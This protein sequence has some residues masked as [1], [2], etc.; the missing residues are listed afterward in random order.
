M[1]VQRTLVDPAGPAAPSP[2]VDLSIAVGQRAPT[3]ELTTVSAESAT[4]H[5]GV[6]VAR[7]DDLEPATRYRFNDV[8]VT[9]LSPPS[10][11]LR[12]RFATVNDVHFGEI[13]AGRLD[14]SELGPIQRPE[15]GAEPYPEVMNRAAVAEIAADVVIDGGER[16][17][18][19]AVFV[20]GDLTDA[21]T[22]EQFAAFAECYGV[23]G[24]QLHVVRG[25]HDGQ[26]GQ[27]EYAG[28]QWVELAGINVALLDTTIAGQVS[29]TLRPEQLDWLDAKVAASTV[30]VM[31]LGH[32][33]MAIGEDAS[34]VLDA[35]STAAL[36]DLA[37]RRPAVIAYAAGHTHRQRV[38]TMPSSGALSIEIACVKDFPGSW[39]SYDVF[40]GG[41]VQLTHRI[42]TPDA[43]RWSERCR[44]LYRD[45]GL[46]YT[47]YALGSIDQRCFVI[48]LR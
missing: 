30:P 15:P 19:D 48:P 34:M 29:G 41:V 26:R 14:D 37:V 17:G 22:P 20:K 39:A 21:G 1:A 13:E 25:N 10:G 4:L 9:T 2:A 27:R 46:D 36:D 24:E 31:V 43:L 40:D 18:H 5:R 11:R 8:V 44:V 7:F 12:A 47:Q 3:W 16:R 38:T 6:E 32:H 23:F 33:P 35:A 45:F 42:S 28:D